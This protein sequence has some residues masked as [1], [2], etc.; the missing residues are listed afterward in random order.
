MEVSSL[1]NIFIRHLRDAGLLKGRI[2]RRVKQMVA[3]LEYQDLILSP[4]V[5]PNSLRDFGIRN[6]KLFEIL[7]IGKIRIISSAA[8]ENPGALASWMI[9][10]TAVKTAQELYD[11]IINGIRCGLIGIREQ[12][13]GKGLE[14]IDEHLDR[15]VRT[16]GNHFKVTQ[17]EKDIAEGVMDFTLETIDEL[18]RQKAT[19]F[20][21]IEIIK[22]EGKRMVTV[23]ATLPW[24]SPNLVAK[25][26][27]L[28]GSAWDHKARPRFLLYDNHQKVTYVWGF[29]Q[30]PVPE[31]TRWRLIQDVLRIDTII[32]TGVNV[33]FSKITDEDPLKLKR[34]F[35][36]CLE[37]QIR[38]S[39]G[40]L[41]SRPD[42]QA[43]IPAYYWDI[44][45]LRDRAKSES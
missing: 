34:D 8:A 6:P 31:I 39:K 23:Y 7:N 41:A 3:D 38:H 1:S 12:E 26:N 2:P 33:N 43:V 28:L 27:Q 45:I 42:L 30:I 4:T 9:G 29:Y 25:L 10:L 21:H 19:V 44:G 5:G 20:I 35:F 11:Q 17:Y 16:R 15:L 18:R 32:V 40:T 13:T 14:D 22:K 24:D 37:N 36:T